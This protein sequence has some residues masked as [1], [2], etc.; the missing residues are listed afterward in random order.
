VRVQDGELIVPQ[1]EAEPV[2][3]HTQRLA[4][5]VAERLPVTPPDDV[6]AVQARPQR[7]SVLQSPRDLF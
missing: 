5:L 7:F 3:E 4:G 6:L 1:L 2:D